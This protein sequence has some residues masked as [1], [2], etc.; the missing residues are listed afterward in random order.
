MDCNCMPGAALIW[1]GSVLSNTEKAPLSMLLKSYS[2]ERHG[3]NQPPSKY[4]QKP[5]LVVS[6]VWD[7]EQW[8][9]RVT[10]GLLQV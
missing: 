3:T 5:R 8:D 4:K 2:R 9:G 6:A 7:I 10:W 1:G